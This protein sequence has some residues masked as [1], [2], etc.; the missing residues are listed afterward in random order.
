[1]ELK[2]PPFGRALYERLKSDTTPIYN[3]YL[4]LGLNAWRDARE[5]AL[6]YADTTLCLPPYV[7]PFAYTYPVYGCGILVLGGA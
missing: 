7:D 6:D 4:F 1:M 5:H 2:L 3:I